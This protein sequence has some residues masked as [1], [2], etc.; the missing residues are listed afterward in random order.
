M[1]SIIK[2]LKYAYHFLWAFLGAC[3]CGFPSRKIFVVA[4][5]GTKG[6][7]TTTELINAILEAAGFKT[8][9]S[10]TLRFKIGADSQP[11]LY[12]MTMPGRAL[13]QRFLKKAVTAGGDYAIIEMTSEGAGQSR[14]RFIDLDALIFTNLAPEHLESHG[15]LEKYLAAKLEL[16]KQLE[17][18]RKQNKTI[19]VN[20][21]DAAAEKFLAINVPHKLRYSLKRPPAE[22]NATVLEGKFNR[23]NVAAAVTFAKTQ[24]IPP[25]TIVRALKQFKGVRGRLEEIVS[26]LFKVIV[27]YAHTP[28]SLKQVYETFKTG[29]K[30]CVFGGTGGGRDRWK[31]PVM[32]RIAA[33]YCSAI[34]L[35]NED[36]YDE[37][38][39]QIVEEIAR[40]IPKEK[41]QIIMD[42][43]QA[44]RQAL[45]E[46]KP[47]DVVIITGKG[48]DPFIMGPRGNKIPWDDAAVVREEFQKL[49]A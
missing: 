10:S 44:I 33:N 19:I 43:R 47:G 9:I 48:T 42:R 35:T 11:N 28:D 34:I 4:V 38:P 2:E 40:A 27:D 30:I 7:T 5:T 26:K 20:A 3:W 8:A 22:I 32:G 12:K 21:D 13:L 25:G 31:R 24:N 23:Y 16:A 36:P 41:C 45:A 17:R 1:I 37:D 49:Y 39:R 46:A 15:S 29:R 14:H 18:S 6:K